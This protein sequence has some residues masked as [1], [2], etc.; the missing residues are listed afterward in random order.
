MAARAGGDPAAKRRELEALRIVAKR[1]A[2]GF[3][4]HLDRRA[5]DAALDAR[6]AARGVHF[7]H[8][9]EVAHVEADRAGEVLADRRLDAADDRRA[10][11]ERN[12]GD[13]P[14]PRP[15]EQGG[16]VGFARGQSHEV[17][18]VGE[19]AGEG[20]HGLGKDLP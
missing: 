7:Q 3:Q 15:V 5:A 10:G 2:M 4:R 11:A 16:D 9:I 12:D 19:V 18:R 6:G 13:S 17:G 14:G 8:A 20:A 1:E